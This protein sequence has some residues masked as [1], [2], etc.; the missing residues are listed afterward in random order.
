[1]RAGRGVASGDGGAGMHRTCVRPMGT[2]GPLAP[3]V[4]RA[5]MPLMK[6]NALR[7]TGTL[8]WFA[9]G[10]SAAGF[11]AGYAGLPSFVALVGGVLVAMVVW[12]DPTGH[13]WGKS[14]RAARRVRPIEEV[15]AELD[16]RAAAG[17]PEALE[18]TAR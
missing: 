3:G 9:V 7:V 6:T 18:R 1:M 2:N 16:Q 13:A 5:T 14:H 12:F 17:A 4:V 8:L 15:A 11:V 10:W